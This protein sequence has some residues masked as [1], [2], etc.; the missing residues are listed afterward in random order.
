M[1]GLTENRP[2]LWSLLGTFILTFMFASESVPGLNKYFQLVPFPD[3]EF[4]DYILR[5]LAIDVTATFFLDRILKFIFCPRIL[6]A[7]VEGTTLKDVLKLSRTIGVMLFL[8]WSFLGND[9]QWEEMMLQEGRLEELGMNATNMTNSTNATEAILGTV[10]ECVG[11][12]CKA[13]ASDGA[14]DEF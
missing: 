7:S 1:T 13:A 4:R 8:M 5:I 11:E 9:D 10:A 14:S 6:F 2:L 12:A 3:D